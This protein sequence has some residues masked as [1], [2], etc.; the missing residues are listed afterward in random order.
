MSAAAEV[1]KLKKTAGTALAF[2]SVSVAAGS[3]FCFQN[4]AF[5]CQIKTIRL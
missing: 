1:K 4:A 3:M 2:I 5:F